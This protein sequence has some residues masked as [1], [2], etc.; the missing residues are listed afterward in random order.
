MTVT[1][2]N[3]TGFTHGY[4]RRNRVIYSYICCY[5]IVTIVLKTGFLG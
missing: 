2:A 1:R 4:F 3:A 5:W